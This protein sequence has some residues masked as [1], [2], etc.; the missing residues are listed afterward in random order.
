MKTATAPRQGAH[1]GKHQARGG[2]D[3]DV[4]RPGGPPR[5]RT[6][7][8]EGEEQPGNVLAE[9][10]EEDD[11][12]G[13]T[14]HVFER[15][16]GA[17]PY[18]GPS[19]RPHAHAAPR[20]GQGQGAPRHA[21]GQ[22]GPRHGQGQGGPRHGQGQGG[23]RHGQGQGGPR[24]G[25]GQGG[26]R[27]GQGQGQGA[28]RHGQGPAGSR[29][30]H[31]HPGGQHAAPGRPPHFGKPRR[32]GVPGH[33]TPASP[34]VMTTLTVPGAIPAGLPGTERSRPQGGGGPAGGG[35]GKNRPRGNRNRRGPKAEGSPGNEAPRNADAAPPDEDF[36]R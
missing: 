2:R 36:N 34:I 1:G 27:H 23:P 16:H 14:A 15:L 20:H 11:V 13:N 30:A 19:A 5:A 32:P 24:H 6:S 28:M 4:E 22:G 9:A 31:G 17:K 33:D 8:A 12:D 7:A 3:G 10:S 25:Q 35:Q 21:Q 26:P 29:P 18:G